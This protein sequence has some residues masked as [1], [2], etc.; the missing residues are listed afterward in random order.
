M[1]LN[2]EGSIGDC[3]LHSYFLQGG[4]KVPAGRRLYM[5]TDFQSGV[6]PFRCTAMIQTDVSSMVPH[7]GISQGLEVPPQVKSGTLVAGRG[8]LLSHGE[9]EQLQR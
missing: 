8:Q 6:S 2:L 4:R 9:G 7:V 1:N 3:N 5:K